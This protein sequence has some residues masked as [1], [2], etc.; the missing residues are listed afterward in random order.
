MK[1]IKVLKVVFDQR[2]AAW[3]V[4]K[5]RGAI[6]EKINRE[7]LLFHN[8]M[9]DDKFRYAYPLIQYKTFNG[10]AGFICI[11]EGTE[12]VHAF[13]SKNN[14]NINLEG[15]EMQLSIKSLSAN[16]FNLQTW[17]TWFYYTLN[18]WIALNKEN[19]DR[20]KCLEG[21]VERLQFL[22]RILTGNILSFS[23]GVGLMVDEPIKL[24]ILEVVREKKVEHK[25]ISLIGFNLDFR[26]NF[27]LPNHIGLGKG[28]STGFGVVR[29]KRKSRQEK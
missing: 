28:V 23:K 14:W 18:N 5:F 1:K 24:E 6:I 16:H 3:Q 25:G 27:F 2:I 12:E 17:D 29:E 4:P 10:N 26:S 9:G 22:E 21:A 11:E 15:R 20:Y 8:H 7:G 13:F 19:Y